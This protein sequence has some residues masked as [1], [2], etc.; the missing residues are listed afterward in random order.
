ME[1]GIQF[2]N[3]QSIQFDILA[4]NIRQE[5]NQKSIVMKVSVN[6]GWS[7]LLPGDMEGPAASEIANN[8]GLRL[9]ST[10]YKIAHHGASRLANRPDWLEKIQPR[11]AFASSGYDYGRCHHP[12]C[13]TIGRLATLNTIT[14]GVQPHQFYCGNR[15][16]DNRRVP[17]STSNQFTMSMYETTPAQNVMCLIKYSSLGDFN[18]NCLIV[19]QL[20]IEEVGD[21]ESLGDNDECPSN[22]EENECPSDHENDLFMNGKGSTNMAG[23]LRGEK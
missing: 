23:N 21:D 11:T 7:A 17:P 3:N 9:Q 6:N 16:V 14:Q 4:A 20:P 5:S 19:Q 22:D 10:V 18:N 1:I 8:I 2:C 15:N 13:E 12:R